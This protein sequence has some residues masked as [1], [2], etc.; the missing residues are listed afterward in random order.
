[1]T[2][3]K[4][5]KRKR[6]I[7]KGAVTRLIHTAE[8]YLLNPVD[9]E[10]SAKLVKDFDQSLLAF[11][12]AHE[13]YHSK[14]QDED[15]QEIS[16]TYAKSVQTDISM[17][18]EKLKNLTKTTANAHIQ[19]PTM[20]SQSK[21]M[22]TIHN[23]L[24]QQLLTLRLPST[25][26][27]KFNGDPLEFPKF[28]MLFKTLLPSIPENETVIHQFTTGQ[29]QNMVEPY[30]FS[31]NFDAAISALRRCYDDPYRIAQGVKCQTNPSEPAAE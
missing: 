1:M 24:Q 28:W 11:N 3:L 29:A 18:Q 25:K 4:E 10:Q 12:E 15:D 17:M 26:I 13:E 8:T 31:G 16:K 5:L 6:G 23:T 7:V 27:P 9:Q 30:L 2:E 22:E 19:L 14:L 21:T 20:P